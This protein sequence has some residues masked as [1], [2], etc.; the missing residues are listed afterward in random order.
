M[1]SRRGAGFT[2]VEL[3]IAMLIIAL[4]L[5]GLVAVS[6]VTSRTST[7]PLIA[8]QMLAIAQ[9]MMEE[10]LLQP[11]GPPAAQPPAG[12]ARDNLASVGA[13]NGYASSGVFTAHGDPLPGLDGYNVAVAVNSVALG[14]AALKV[15]VT[16]TRG[17]ASFALNGWRTQP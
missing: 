3:I 9:G 7:D 2:L 15:T 16:V 17:N 13:F 10:V 11:Y 4:A 14:G 5:G 1:S 12:P 6:R 8:R